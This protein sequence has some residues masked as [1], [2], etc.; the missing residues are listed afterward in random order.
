MDKFWAKVYPAC[1]ATGKNNDKNEIVK[2]AMQ[3]LGKIKIQKL[4]PRRW[5]GF[6]EFS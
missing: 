4:M 3:R 1:P 5:R 6:Q 2:V